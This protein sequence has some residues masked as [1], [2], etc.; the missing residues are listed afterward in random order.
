MVLPAASLRR[1]FLFFFLGAC[2]FYP[3]SNAF[4]GALRRRPAPRINPAFSL[5]SRGAPVAAGLG[6][7]LAG[8]VSFVAIRPFAAWPV[9]QRLDQ[10]MASSQV[11]LVGLLQTNLEEAS[12]RSRVFEHR[13]HFTLASTGLAREGLFREKEKIRPQRG[14]KGE[15][16]RGGGPPKEKK[17]WER[18]PPQQRKPPQ[19]K[20]GSRSAGNI[21][22]AHRSPCMICAFW[23]M[24]G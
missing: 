11:C 12:R 5:G 18:A 21:F 14:N 17:K 15:K 8:V 9:L 20:K 19:K 2:T 24:L 22:S 16:T 10:L 13:S 3:L 4:T 6:L 1:I 7:R 23:Q